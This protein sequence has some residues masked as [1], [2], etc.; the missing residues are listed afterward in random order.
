MRELEVLDNGHLKLGFAEWKEFFEKDMDEWV[1]SQL[2]RLIERALEAER[3]YQLQL[4]YYEHAPQPRLDYRN[5]Y[6]LRDLGTRLGLLRGLRMPRTRRG[7][8]SHFVPRYKRREQAVNELVRQAFLRGVSTRQVGEVLEPVLGE[9]YSAQTVSNITREL[10]RAVE[11]YH[12]RKLDDGYIYLFLDGV[13]LKVR[14]SSGKVRRRVVLVAYGITRSGRRELIDYQFAYGGESEASWVG[15]LQHLFLRGLEGKNLRLIVSDGGKGLAAAL[16]V[17]LPGIPV[18]LCWAH[19]LRNI[20]DKVPRR[21]SSCVAEAASIYRAN[22]RSEA[23][24][25]FRQW[26]Q[27]WEHRR[28]RAVACVERDLDSLLHFLEVPRAHW[29]KV[30]TTNVIE[31]AFREVRRRTRPMSSFSNPASCDRIVF[32][33]TSHLNRS[34][35]R[36]PLDEFTQNA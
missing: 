17:V 24:Q 33:V 20:A 35:Q 16:P 1:R 23:Q 22:S 10:D 14:D 36:K 32:G 31:R 29:K 11:Q 8:R 2:K 25:A 7:F 28:P 15:F 12:Q 4:G 30:R 26:K 34:W 3:D 13:V 9:A 6:Y 18:Q 19:K 5:G 27:H 21:E